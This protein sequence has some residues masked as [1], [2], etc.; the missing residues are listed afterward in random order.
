LDKDEPPSNQN[1]N[2]ESQPSNSNPNEEPQLS[3]I[4]SLLEAQLK[5]MGIDDDMKILGQLN[6]L[7]NQLADQPCEVRVKNA[8][9]ITS[10]VMKMFDDDDD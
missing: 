5:S 4:N 10:A 7:R 8:E 2:T 6:D 3:N 1:P 9:I